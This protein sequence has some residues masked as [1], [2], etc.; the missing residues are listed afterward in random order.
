MRI[1]ICNNLIFGG[2]V[3]TLLQIFVKDFLKRGNDV[4]VV[5][6]PEDPA[7]FR[8]A[9]PPGVHCIRARL[10]KKRY[11]NKICSFVYS[12]KRKAFRLFSILKVMAVK[13]DVAISMKEGIVMKD[14]ASL[15]ARKKFAWIQCDYRE[16]HQQQGRDNHCSGR[17]Q[18]SR[19]F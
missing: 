9:F 11:K 12:L 7:D 8:K 19:V 4:T 10:P 1:I 5:A 3:E 2:G 16:F 6:S 13:Y 17:C 15:R 18:E 14:T